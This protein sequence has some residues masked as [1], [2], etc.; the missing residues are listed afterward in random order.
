EDGIRDFHV[1][2]VQTCALPISP[3]Q[4]L[5]QRALGLPTPAYLHLPLLRG[6][7]GRKLSKSEA[8]LP[9]DPGDPL[10]SLQLAWQRLGQTALA[11]PY[12]A[13]PEAFLEAAAAH[14]DARR[15]PR[16]LPPVDG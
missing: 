13:G 1:T 7:D 3:R 4:M 8:D 2:G 10:P 11:L 14:F 9:L 6:R 5:L 12:S 15:I 16:C